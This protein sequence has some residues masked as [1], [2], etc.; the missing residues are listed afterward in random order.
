MKF[1]T[2]KIIALL[3]CAVM[4][5]PTVLTSCDMLNNPSFEQEDDEN[6]SV[7]ETKPKRET[8]KSKESDL[9]PTESESAPLSSPESTLEEAPVS[10][11]KETPAETP[12]EST[13]VETPE[14]SSK[15]YSLS[16]VT[17]E[18][19]GNNLFASLSNATTSF[20]FKND[21]IL[22]GNA[23]FTISLD[24]YGMQSIVT[25][26]VS[27]NEGDNIFY[28]HVDFGNDVDTY[29]VSIR[30]RPMYTVI[31]D[32]AGGT[33]I[34]NQTVEEDSLVTVPTTEKEGYT[35]IGWDRDTSLPIT[36]NT[37]FT[38]QWLGNTHTVTYDTNGGNIENHTS[39]VICGSPYTLET[40]IKTGYVFE[41]WYCENTKVDQS[42]NWSITEDV[43]LTAK[44]VPSTNTRYTVEH[45]IEQPNGTY[46]RK[47]IEVFYG[48]TDSSVT[49]STKLYSDHI[50]PEEQTATVLPDGSLVIKYYYTRNI[51][52]ID[53]ALENFI[54][55]DLVEGDIVTT[56]GYA[57]S[58][59][60][61]GT[62]QNGYAIMSN[63]VGEDESRAAISFDLTVTDFSILKFNVWVDS[64]YG[65][66][67]YILLDGT[68]YSALGECEAGK[69][70]VSVFLNEGYHTVTL[71]YSKDYSFS[72]GTDRVYVSKATVETL[73]TAIDG[74]KDEFYAGA[75]FKMVKNPHAGTPESWNGGGMAYITHDDLGLYI[76]VEVTD[77]DVIANSDSM[78][79]NEDKVQIY[80]DYARSFEEEGVEGIDYRYTATR[81]GMKLGWVIVTPDGSCGASYGF[82]HPKADNDQP[83]PGV[84]AAAVLTE[85]GYAVEIFIP[86]ATEVI[87]DHETIGLGIQIG[88]D[89]SDKDIDPNATFYSELAS[90]AAFW[91]RD[92]EK[93]PEYIIK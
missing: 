87:G 17:L 79:D 82:R 30:R 90:Q 36:S 71:V 24:E 14:E 60:W 6:D 23:T 46:K 56:N 66:V 18:Q 92:Y 76:Y 54:T 37:T 44:W 57:G 43:V 67:F 59:L 31:F 28:L 48:T 42:G 15:E 80:L 91:W 2:K 9:K 12:T 89:T 93:L 73:P 65:D 7:K 50:A 19:S 77:S 88:D 51:I 39:S 11:P 32:A 26:S 53:Q 86:F 69:Y 58:R 49:P 45:Y 55:G 74:V 68:K 62:T 85:T 22:Q 34:S 35:F 84:I 1:P 21:V 13:P 81:G 38:A 29:V 70:D 41:G 63:N 61:T 3:L 20:S 5:F 16:F 64:D 10:T 83:V 72:A 47:N 78:V 33:A 27:L 52:S 8:T 40:P 25:K 75:T 4:I